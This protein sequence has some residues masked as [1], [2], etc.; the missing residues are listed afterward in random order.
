MFEKMT[1]HMAIRFFDTILCKMFMNEKEVVTARKSIS[2]KYAK[3]VVVYAIFQKSDSLF[4]TTGSKERLERLDSLPLVAITCLL[5]ASKFEETDENCLR[6]HE[7]EKE[8]KYKYTFKNITSCEQKILEEIN[9]N[10]FIQ[11]PYYYI[12][13]YFS[14]GVL[15]SD[16]EYYQDGRFITFPHHNDVN[17]HP[18]ELKDFNT[19]YDKLKK[20]IEGDYDIHS[21]DLLKFEDRLVALAMICCARKDLKIRPIISPHF[22]KLYDFHVDDINECMDILM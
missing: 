11:T 15:F 4:M 14:S 20:L 18:Q 8:Y 2:A 13:L 22:A 1:V 10:T 5:I 3:T 19:L 17:S 9:W 16:D 6:I 7:L 12:N 21:Y